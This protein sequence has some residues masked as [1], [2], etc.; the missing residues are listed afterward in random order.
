MVLR[1]SLRMVLRV[2][3]KMVL[4]GFLNM[5]LRVFSKMV[6][7]AYLAR[8]KQGRGAGVGSSGHGD[9]PAVTSQKQ[10]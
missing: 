5:V 10:R 7:R 3:L 6:L 2:L 4:R 1:V 8:A 9:R